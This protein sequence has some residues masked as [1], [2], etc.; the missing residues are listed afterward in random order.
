MRLFWLCSSVGGCPQSPQTALNGV[1]SWK[2]SEIPVAKNRHMSL[3]VGVRK[4][5]IQ[6][7]FRLEDSERIERV[8]AAR[9]TNFPPAI[10]QFSD[11]LFACW[12]LSIVPLSVFIKK[13]SVVSSPAMAPK[14]EAHLSSIDTKPRRTFGLAGTAGKIPEREIQGSKGAIYEWPPYARNFWT[15]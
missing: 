13:T 2:R 3:H 7:T 8:G 9:T 11:Y 15:S 5:Y 4:L 12:S 14:P 1:H 10:N 6:S